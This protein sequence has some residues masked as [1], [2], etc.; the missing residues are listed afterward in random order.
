M[1]T[2]ADG[3]NVG[4]ERLGG[5]NGRLRS[6]NGGLSGDNG[7]LGGDRGRDREFSSYN[8]E[9]VGHGEERSLG[10]GIDGRL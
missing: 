2:R 10:E 8:T 6:H 1:E 9:G 7:G 3:G 4:W 5:D